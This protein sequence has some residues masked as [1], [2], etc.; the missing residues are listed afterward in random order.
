MNNESI[1]INNISSNK[2]G[3]EDIDHLFVILVNGLN[4]IFV[5]ATRSTM[6]QSHAFTKF[7]DCFV[8][9]YA[10]VLTPHLNN[11]VSMTILTGWTE[12]LVKVFEGKYKAD[13]G[14]VYDLAIIPELLN[15][16]YVDIYQKYL[17]P[18]SEKFYLDS[19]LSTASNSSEPS[20]QKI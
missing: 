2:L 8:K 11:G 9:N 6:P 5:T 15:E 7:I 1:E 17:K 3:P 20:V 13:N 14:K 16:P 4:Q 19:H 12:N 18:I 10:L